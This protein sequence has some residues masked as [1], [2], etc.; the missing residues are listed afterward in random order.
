MSMTW[1]H[2]CA[3]LGRGLTLG[4]GTTCMHCGNTP[5]AEL[6]ATNQKLEDMTALRDGAMEQYLESQ[7]AWRKAEAERKVDAE[8]ILRL[9]T[10]VKYLV[11]IAERGRGE[12]I[13]DTETAEQFVLCYV[14]QLESTVATLKAERKEREEQEPFM[15]ITTSGLRVPDKTVQRDAAIANGWIA[16]YT[17]PAD[18]Q[19]R[20]N[21]LEAEVTRLS[22]ASG[23]CIECERLSRENVKLKKKLAEWQKAAIERE[24]ICVKIESEFPTH[25]SAARAEGVEEGRKMAVPEGFVVVPVR[26]TAY[27]IEQMTGEW[28][29]DKQPLTRERYAAMLSAA[30]THKEE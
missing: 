25:L 10:T 15:W 21:E 6:A 30:P 17:R 18:L 4:A 28:H 19:K 5:E 7:K 12:H 29:I 27:M 16:C 26:P 23:F 13:D 1:H 2:D 9:L 11:G 14:R 3:K 24:A 20:I 22:G 8:S